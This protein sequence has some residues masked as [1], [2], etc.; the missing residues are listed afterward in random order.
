MRHRSPKCHYS[1]F[2]LILCLALQRVTI[3]VSEGERSFYHSVQN[4]AAPAHEALMLH[5]AAANDNSEEAGPSSPRE[6]PHCLPATCWG[7]MYF[8]MA[9]IRYKVA[10][11]SKLRLRYFVECCGTE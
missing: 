5:A 10:M 6:N 11:G 3:I 1:G 4:A 9:N 7:T 8:A 2:C